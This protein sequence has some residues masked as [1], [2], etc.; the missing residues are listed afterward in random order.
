MLHRWLR[1]D[2]IT[3][4]MC[5]SK[6]KL[7]S[8]HYTG[9]FNRGLEVMACAYWSGLKQKSTWFLHLLVEHWGNSHFFQ[10][11]VKCVEPWFPPPLLH[12]PAFSLINSGHANWVEM[13]QIIDNWKSYCVAAKR[14]INCTDAR[15]QIYQSPF[16]S[17]IYCV[18][19]DSNRMHKWS[20]TYK[21][22][23]LTRPIFTP[24]VKTS[25]C[26]SVGH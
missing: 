18:T 15:T 6:L 14:K 19:L 16:V 5:V 11:L 4:V 2:W 25:P 7:E 9:V 1:Q 13:Y 12:R 3:L 8:K 23:T 20:E 22:M 26:L 10:L 17:L 24:C 21:P